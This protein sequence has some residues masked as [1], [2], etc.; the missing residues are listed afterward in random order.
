M[1]SLLQ[2]CGPSVTFLA[3]MSAAGGL[4]SIVQKMSKLIMFLSTKSSS[5]KSLLL[6]R[7]SPIS[8]PSCSARMRSYRA[9]SVSSSPLMAASI[10]SSELLLLSL[11]AS[12]L[13]LESSSL[14]SSTTSSICAGCFFNYYELLR[15]AFWISMPRGE[16]NDICLAT[17]LQLWSYRFDWVSTL[18]DLNN[19]CD[20]LW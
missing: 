4:V 18:P 3:S 19:L 5:C 7:S 10:D 14:C 20:P 6:F 2:T 12:L 17:R 8:L 1:R 13:A 11:V 16:A 15:T 9:Y